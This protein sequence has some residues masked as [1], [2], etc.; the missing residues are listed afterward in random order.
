MEIV[1]SCGDNG[2][3]SLFR[4]QIDEVIKVIHGKDLLTVVC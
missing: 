4:N 2:I 1:G 3:R